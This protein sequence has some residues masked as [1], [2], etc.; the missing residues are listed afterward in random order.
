MPEVPDIDVDEPEPEPEPQPYRLLM[1]MN[2]E[3]Y[4]P[5]ASGP[6]QA[7]YQGSF[8]SPASIEAHSFSPNF[9]QSPPGSM[10]TP[11]WMRPVRLDEVGG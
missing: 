5:G 3:E 6:H 2:I 10:G 1:S 8:G 9:Q 7:S 11:P 4:P